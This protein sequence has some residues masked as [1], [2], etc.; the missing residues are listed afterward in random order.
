VGGWDVLPKGSALFMP[1]K[2]HVIF[3]NTVY[4][5][6][7]PTKEALMSEIERQIREMSDNIRRL[8]PIM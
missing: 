2:I 6:D 3:G 5:S 7:Y 4:P 8:T 1:K